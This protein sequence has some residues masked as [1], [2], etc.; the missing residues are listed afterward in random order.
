MF[1][2]YSDVN[3]DSFV[4]NTYLLAVG[5]LPTFAAGDK[6]YEKIVAI[7]NLKID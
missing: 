4:S 7:A 2:A 5:K 1:F 6:K 3:R